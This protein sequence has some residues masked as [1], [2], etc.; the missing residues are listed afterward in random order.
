MLAGIIDQPAYG[1][2]HVRTRRPMSILP[3][4]SIST[5]STTLGLTGR[6][7]QSLVAYCIEGGW[8]SCLHWVVRWLGPREKEREP[9]SRPGLSVLTRVHVCVRK[10]VRSSS[11]NDVAERGDK[12]LQIALPAY[13][14]RRPDSP[15]QGELWI[16]VSQTALQFPRFPFSLDSVGS[17]SVR[18]MHL[19]L[20]MGIS[21]DKNPESRV[22]V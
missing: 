17:G 10:C 4:Q 22:Q 9:G 5:S 14:V 3:G 21:C 11:R 1:V 12:Q 15:I 18:V 8:Q 2:G 20:H 13:P 6:R 7:K 19:T 16:S